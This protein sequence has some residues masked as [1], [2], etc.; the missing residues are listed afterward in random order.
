MLSRLS[1]E[2]LAIIE[3]CRIE[4]EPGL[5]LLTGETGAGKSII[6]GALNLIL[7][8]RAS[9]DDVRTGAAQARVEAEFDLSR[10]PR[11]RQTLQTRGL[12]GDDPEALIVRREIQATGKSRHFINGAAVQLAEVREIAGALVDLH[13]QHQHQTLLDPEEHLAALDAFGGHDDLLAE[14]AQRHAEFSA[15][16]HKL[17]SLLTDERQTEREKG[18][19]RFQIDEI[20]AAALQPGEDAELELE[21]ARL[22]NAE[23]LRLRAHA[24]LDRLYEGESTE[25]S[26]VQLLGEAL[27]EIDALARIDASLQPMNESLAGARA[28]IEDAVAELRAYGARIEA[29]PQRLQEVE[30]R[31]DLIKKLKRKYGETIEAI[32][33]E[34]EAMTR[35]L[36]SL[37]NREA[38]IAE[39]TRQR[40]AARAALGA[41]AGRLSAKRRAA[42]Q[43]WT[44]EIER[45]LADLSMPHTRCSV[46][47]SFMPDPDGVAL[48]GQTVAVAPHGAD[49]AEL[50]ISPNPGEDLRPLKKIA[51]GGELSR[52]MLALKSIMAAKDRVPILVFDEVDAG[53]SG[54]V[55]AKV[56]QQIEALA[57][58]HQVLCIT[59]LPQIAACKGAHFTVEKTERAGRTVSS[60]RRLDDEGRLDEIAE[61]FSG[62]RPTPESRAHAR[63]LLTRR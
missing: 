4:F 48:D 39:T 51:S 9:S 21:R 46:A 6:I 52:V 22:A 12:A 3:Q 53:I 58:S 49:H 38:E 26:A 29:D 14:C 17:R 13:G 59:H 54:A 25:T 44:A 15:L 45:R 55:A 7:G 60:V 5:N 42:A 47:F 1:I 57:R 28:V 2:N 31:L 36:D 23:T 30:D 8:E 35:R 33:A 62:A 16:S 40:D 41:V 19:L 24:A 37:E 34:A 10:L 56:G 11:V 18:S 61:L 63:A 20:A 27:G 43:R 50:M 32:L